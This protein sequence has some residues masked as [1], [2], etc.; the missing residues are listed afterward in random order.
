MKL[1][2]R[3][4]RKIGDPNYGSTGIEFELEAQVDDELMYDEPDKFAETVKHHFAVCDRMLECELARIYSSRTTTAAGALVRPPAE[5]NGHTDGD[6]AI[7]DA[8]Q[9]TEPAGAERNGHTKERH[10]WSSRQSS[11]GR[12]DRD[13]DRDRGGDRDR[14]RDRGR[15]NDRQS[16]GPAPRN[17]K[18]L[19][20]WGK[21]M[22]EK[23]YGGMVTRLQAY[24]RGQGYPFKFSECSRDEIADIYRE[25]LRLLDESD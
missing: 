6:R 21:E 5:R 7:E 19:F 20:A 16:G 14:G 10:E 22:E 13:R 2:F 3:R 17:G 8:R 1:T 25:G 9:R 15:S 11:G 18:G 24:A 12:D 23:G 4:S